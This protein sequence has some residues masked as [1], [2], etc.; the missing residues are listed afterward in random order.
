MVQACIAAL[1][2]SYTTSSTQ[3]PETT[4]W[5]LLKQLQQQEKTDVIRD[6]EMMEV[7]CTMASLAP[8]EGSQAETEE[9][10][11]SLPVLRSGKVVSNEKGKTSAEILTLGREPRPQGQATPS[12]CP[13]P[14]T[15]TVQYDVITHLRRIPARLSVYEALQLSR[16][17]REA[18][19]K[20]LVNEDV[21][22]AYL[23]ES[24][25]VAECAETITFTDEDLLLGDRQH[26]RPLFVSGDL[27][28][29]RINRILLDAGSAVNILPLKT[30]QRLG[31]GPS[32]LKKTSLVI[33]GSRLGY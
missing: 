24:A 23:A 3:E 28:G 7:S 17:A 27:G 10:S 25:G 1:G 12:V 8:G 31:Y 4:F 22:D 21:R 20:A 14:S 18:L 32:Q 13:G 30:L 15:D 6:Q 9:V 16:E 33:Q 19:I 2:S 11:E 26:N 29:E 5:E